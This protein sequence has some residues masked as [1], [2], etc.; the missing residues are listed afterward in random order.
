MIIHQMSV[1][2]L[3]TST[4]E[5]VDFGQNSRSQDQG[6]RLEDD[7]VVLQGNTTYFYQ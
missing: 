6:Q 5:N 1:H 4:D 2:I 3:D 7:P